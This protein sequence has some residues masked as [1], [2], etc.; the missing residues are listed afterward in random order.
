M[1][2]DFFHNVGLSPSRGTTAMW[3]ISASPVR[4]RCGCSP[5]LWCSSLVLAA[6]LAGCAS[7]PQK[8][9]TVRPGPAPAWERDGLGGKPPSDLSRLP[10][11]EPR[12]EAIRYGGPNKPYEVLG[13]DYVP[14]HEDKPMA[15]RGL[16]SWYGKKFHGR[17][18]ASGEVYNMYAMTAAH[19]TM[20]LPSYAR[21]R[22]PKNGREVIVR[23]NDRGPFHPGRVI[24]LS[25]AAAVKLG[26]QNGVAPVELER[27]THEE[28]RTGSWR[29][30]SE[31]V[32][33]SAAPPPAEAA[34]PAD[35]V[36]AVA[37]VLPPPAAEPPPPVPDPAPQASPSP[38]YTSTAQGFW[39]QLGAFKQRT[40]AEQFQRRVTE[41]LDWLG[42]LLAV[43]SEPS[44]Y[45][46]Q[47]GP[48]T[49]RQD[50]QAAA[51]RIRE[52]IQLVPVIVERRR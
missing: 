35:D 20:P 4:T 28:I 3:P 11:A 43:F 45:R 5:G 26:V 12:V 50:A 27:I 21:V 44:L 31:P 37:A 23:V 29:R 7:P 8:S 48:Y 49:S 34:P 47:A 9:P 52:A 24:D 39:L 42:P 15:E 2:S 36:P 6:L 1:A 16:A 46:L 25:Y 30:G 32:L 51:E 14:Q 22:N 19:K 40:G 10:D 17:R 13:R 41:E 18:T 33:T 38:A